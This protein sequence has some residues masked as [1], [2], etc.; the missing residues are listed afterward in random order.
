MKVPRHGAITYAFQQNHWP[1]LRFYNE[2][3]KCEKIIDIETLIPLV[4]VY[5][6][7]DRLIESIEVTAE[8]K[9][10]DIMNRILEID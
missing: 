7:K 10:Q 3:L 8:L 9:S 1:V 4:L 6:H 5:D 2:E